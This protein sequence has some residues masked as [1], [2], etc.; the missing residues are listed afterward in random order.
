ML[1]GSMY[2]CFFFVHDIRED[3]IGNPLCVALCVCVCVCFSLVALLRIGLASSSVVRQ[4]REYAH[5]GR[6]AD[7]CNDSK[8]LY[9]SQC[10]VGILF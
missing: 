4:Q 8:R 6:S 3:C 2:F 7:Y 10:S 9:A 1:L 5:I